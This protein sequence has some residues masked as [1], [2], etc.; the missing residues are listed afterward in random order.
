[1]LETWARC[2]TQDTDHTASADCTNNQRLLCKI[3]ATSTHAACISV[4]SVREHMQ[5]DTQPLSAWRLLNT[6][7]RVENAETTAPALTC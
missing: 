4:R 7:L 1:M 6:T 5:S 2:V 3:P